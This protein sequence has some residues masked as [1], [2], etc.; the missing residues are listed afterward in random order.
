MATSVK[1]NDSSAA[2]MAAMDY[3]SISPADRRQGST[4]SNRAH[5]LMSMTPLQ[6]YS[7]PSMTQ[8]QRSRLARAILGDLVSVECAWS[9]QGE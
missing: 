8:P 2:V 1:A 5:V 3:L 9:E 6:V 7:Y 4:S